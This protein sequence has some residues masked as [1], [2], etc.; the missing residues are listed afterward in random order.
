ML[1]SAY[2]L[3]PGVLAL[4]LSV[5][6][7]ALAADSAAQTLPDEDKT[8]IIILTD[9]GNEPD[10]AQ[11]LVRFLVYSNEFDVEGLVATTS[12]WLRD[13]V[14][15]QMIKKRID[16]YAQVQPALS[17]HAAGYPSAASLRAVVRSGKV[18]FGMAG[19]GANQST[20]ASR[21]II[22]AVDKQ[23]ARPLWINLWG[24]GV[25][26][27]QAL[28]DIRDSR[29]PAEVA[30][31]VSKLRVYAI[32]DQDNSGVWIRRNFPELLWITSIHAWNDYF[33]ATWL[34]MSASFA[35]GGDMSMVNNTWLATNI[36]NKGP[37]G[38]VYP[39]IEYTMEGD[40]PAFLYL[41]RNGLGDVEHPEYGS[42]GG[43]YAAMAPDSSEG[44]RVSTSDDVKGADGKQ[45]RTAA[46]TVW[47]WRAAF[48]QDFAA[49]MDWSVSNSVKKAN[50]NPEL[51]LN[52]QPGTA[53]VAWEVHA[54]EQVK[55]SASGSTDRDGNHLTYRW[56]QYKEPTATA[57]QLH[58]APELPLDNR[59]GQHITFRAPQVK[60]ATPFHI[61]L[62]VQD[63][64]T[65]TLTSYRR[66]IVT[67]Q[68]SKK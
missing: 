61:I 28:Y 10:D 55:L 9:I 41:L 42:W 34:G 14:N 62:E 6:A 38:A 3:R 50:H 60:V 20:E 57:M 43:R 25:D 52:G 44:L 58:F 1:H 56:W 68:P 49:R 11:S 59:E 65:P 46:A 35:T 21:L 4:L 33:L 51:V 39:A 27:A 37:L 48:Q 15:P 13:R 5:S 31:F 23:D 32:S 12:T 53:N 29:T 40:T 2:S 22:A 16:A 66:A 19:V 8:R 18:A 24:G 17:L 64:G 45:Y 7:P 63:D 26:L 67:V 36:R 30:T 54:G 47:R